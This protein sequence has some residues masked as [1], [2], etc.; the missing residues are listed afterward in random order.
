MEHTCAAITGTWLCDS[1]NTVT[2]ADCAKLINLDVAVRHV[3]H[4]PCR[5]P[6]PSCPRRRSSDFLFEID[7]GDPQSWRRDRQDFR[8]RDDLQP[9]AQCAYL[10]PMSEEFMHRSAASHLIHTP[11]SWDRIGSPVFCDH[12]VWHPNTTSGSLLARS[13]CRNGLAL[14]VGLATRE[15]QRYPWL[16]YSS[17][18]RPDYSTRR[19]LRCINH[20][21]RYGLVMKSHA[22]GAT[23]SQFK[24]HAWESTA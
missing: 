21:S 9:C 1:M 3:T 2:A 20:Q 13:A 11:R 24:T 17:A 8:G 14:P 19:K 23:G 6:A 5:G 16:R 7:C 4:V 10:T 22:Y 15:P 12:V 18:R